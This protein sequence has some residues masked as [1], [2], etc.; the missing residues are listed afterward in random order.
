MSRSLDEAVILVGH[1]ITASLIEDQLRARHRALPDGGPFKRPFIM[2]KT[3]VAAR[4]TIA[5][6]GHEDGEASKRKALIKTGFADVKSIKGGA[7]SVKGVHL[8]SS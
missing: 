2:R 5:M 1:R 8:T 7:V 4:I 6:I 3:A